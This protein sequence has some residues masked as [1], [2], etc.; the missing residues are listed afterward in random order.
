M[1][2]Q[3]HYSWRSN[4]N[5][6][7]FLAFKIIYTMVLGGLNHL[8]AI[9]MFSNRKYIHILHSNII[10]SKNLNF[11]HMGKFFSCKTEF[12]F[13]DTCI[14]I[15]LNVVFFTRII[16]GS[17]MYTLQKCYLIFFYH[18]IYTVICPFLCS[19]E[20]HFRSVFY[21]FKRQN[22]KVCYITCWYCNVGFW[23][24]ILAILCSQQVSYMHMR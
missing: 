23:L 1:S 18:Y 20:F 16:N 21:F 13:P 9:G 24:T 12:L 7:F 3:G 15:L 11:I 5:L 17:Y 8:A 10:F 19:A 6:H 14:Y 22:I 2:I 4:F